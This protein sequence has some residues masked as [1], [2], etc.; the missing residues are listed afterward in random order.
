L[1]PALVFF[2]ISLAVEETSA[3]EGWLEDAAGKRIDVTGSCVVGRSNN[4]T[5]VLPDDKVS[6]RHAMIQC[7]SGHEFWLIDLGSAN[8]TYLNGRRIVQPS[9]LNHGDQIKI[10]DHRFI[11][12]L[13][14]VAGER[15]PSSNVEQTV[16]EIKTLNCWLLVADIES[17]TQLAQRV[18][19]DE[20]PQLTGRW[21]STCKQIVEDNGGTI[22]KFLGDGF[23]AYWYAGNDV[24]ARLNGAIAAL[25]R[26]QE[27]G[28][29]R[30]R[31]V[32]H[33]GRVFIGGGASLG[34]ESLFGTDVNFVFRMEKLAGVL[35]TTRLVSDPA[36]TELKT[37]LAAITDEGRHPLPGFDGD[38]AFYS[39]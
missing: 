35:G 20:L 28:Q 38:H 30:F 11:F 23:F 34:E 14:E 24:A 29:L 27:M 5:I 16:Q 37:H 9:R 6:R 13:A 39:F 22:N 15:A 19:A 10:G 3:P 7:Q 25:Q 26:L 21:L 4:S 36:K 12:R 2:G 1:F 18:S 8:G 31:F 17:S 32:V 33:F